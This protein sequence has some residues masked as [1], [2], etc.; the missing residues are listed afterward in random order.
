MQLANQLVANVWKSGKCPEIIWLI[1]DEFVKRL[2]VF[3]Q[4]TCGD[5]ILSFAQ[6]D[7]LE[8]LFH[9]QKQCQSIALFVLGQVQNDLR[10]EVG[11]HL[12]EEENGAKMSLIAHY[13][14]GQLLTI[15]GEGNL[16]MIGLF[17]AI[18]NCS[19]WKPIHAQ[20]GPL[21]VP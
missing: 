21:V 1:F 5:E 6:A 13:I 7:L 18:F 12:H 20:R 4:A 2:G 10:L 3:V 17:Q 16:D 19:I 8:K 11:K 14:S 9:K 15:R